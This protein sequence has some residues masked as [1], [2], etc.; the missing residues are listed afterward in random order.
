MWG[1][2]DKRTDSL[3]QQ[4]R[5]TAKYRNNYDKLHRTN[6]EKIEKLKTLEG[7]WKYN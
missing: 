6:H 3:Q 4:Q 5:L 2:Y 1:H 7:S